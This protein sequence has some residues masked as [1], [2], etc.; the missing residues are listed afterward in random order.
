M[1]AMSDLKV[2]IGSIGLERPGMVASGIMDET[3]DTMVRMLRSGA[4]A[5]VSKSV[6]SVPNPGHRNPNFTEVPCGCINAMG[7]PN[8]GI[9][10]FAEEMEVAVKE[11]PIVG[12]VYGASPEEF[13]RLAGR[14]EDYGACAVELNLSCPHAKGYG[15]EVGTDP[16]MVA[17]IVSAVKDVVKVPVW[18]KLTPNTHILPEIGRAVEDAGGDAI[19]AIN[20]LKAM[21]IVPEFGKPLLSNK[22]CGLSGKCIKPIGVRA[23]W[24]LYNSV[25]IPI[26]GVGGIYDHRDAI[27]YIMAGASAFQLGTAVLTEG[28][29]VFSRI[30][31]GMSR[32]MDEYGYS[33]IEDMRGVAHE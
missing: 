19:V 12:S 1:V 8:P 27:E 26:V 25:S 11:G 6:G 20:T 21:V 33:S 14:M 24:D 28:V 31:E 3:G 9:D 23:V 30:N 4:G 15:M 32:F 5:V 17:S 16:K 22:V 18:T 7:L 29:D 10:A 13:A 2:R